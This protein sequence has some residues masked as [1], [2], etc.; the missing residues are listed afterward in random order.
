[1]G[2]RWRRLREDNDVDEVRTEMNVIYSSNLGAVMNS[3]NRSGPSI[4]NPLPMLQTLN[5]ED[6]LT[7]R[8]KKKS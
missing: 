7:K 4:P 2:N 1:M 6:C 5:P 8:S 3:R